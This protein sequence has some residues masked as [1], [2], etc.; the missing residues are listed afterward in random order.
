MQ[1]GNMPTLMSQASFDNFRTILDHLRLRHDV[2]N[3]FVPWTGNSL[4]EAGGIYYIGIATDGE[5]YPPHVTVHDLL[6]CAEFLETS[7][8]TGRPH[9]RDHSPFWRYLDGLTTAL[10][11]AH[12]YDCPDRWG[13]SNLLKIASNEHHEPSKWHPDVIGE[14]RAACGQ[15]LAEEFQALANSVVIVVSANDF[16]VLPTAISGH[17]NWD[18]TYEDEGIWWWFDRSTSNLYVHG[19]HPNYVQQ[20][21]LPQL[22]RTIE[23]AR[24]HVSWL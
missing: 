16:D 24:S 20:Q 3:V 13:W 19:N 6:C 5:C 17:A 18:K 10:M 12:Y 8:C 22:T 15:A 1:E 23:L 7:L 9:E 14:Q 21:K 4:K 2:A 11:G